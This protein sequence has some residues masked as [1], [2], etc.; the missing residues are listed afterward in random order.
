MHQPA[1]GLLTAALPCWTVSLCSGRGK[2]GALERQDKALQYEDH[3]RGWG[4][5]RGTKVSELRSGDETKSWAWISLRGVSGERGN[6]G[7]TGW[8]WRAL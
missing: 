4:E 6:R 5:A 2:E 7:C 8:S 1:S 3:K